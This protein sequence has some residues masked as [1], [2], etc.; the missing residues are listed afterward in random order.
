MSTLPQSPITDR[1]AWDA[2]SLGQNPGWRYTFTPEDCSEIAAAVGVAHEAGLSAGEFSR[3][4]FPLPTVAQKIA[5]VMDEVE[6]GPG[7]GLFS[8]LPVDRY[9]E[10]TTRTAYWGLATHFGTA[11]SQNSR[12]ERMAEVI[13]R[14][15]D[16]DDMNVRGYKTKAALAPHVD[17]CAM[18]TLLCVQSAQ[19]GGD[20]LITSAIN[21]YNRVLAEFPEY[22]DVYE[23][24]FQHDLRGEGPTGRLD[25]VTHHEIPVFSY[26]A[27]RLSCAFNNRI[28]RS[29]REK[30]GPP[31]STHEIEAIDLI[32]QLAQD[33]RA[34][35]RMRLAPG[36]IQIV[37]NYTVLHAR[38]TYE[39]S[40]IADE[41]RCL[42]RLWLN[43][44]VARNV[45]PNFADR[46]NTGPGGGV[47]VGDGARYAF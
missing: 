45:A 6:H 46:Y 9:D 33:P 47:A 21:V 35:Y 36:D 26:H 11:I 2:D 14:G 10:R 41:K 43:P 39:D 22:L 16:H 5:R 20:S 23:R 7:V 15:N 34:Q 30:V 3:D 44:L 17:S 38:D 4:N 8:G 24:G 18:T 28:M 31:L 13:D 19:N 42:L 27:G 32:I 12:G 37:N 40:T 25:E 1:T 29:A